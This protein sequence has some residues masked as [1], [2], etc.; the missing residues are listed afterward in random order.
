MTAVSAPPVVT[1]PVPRTLAIVLAAGE[2]TRM[3][4]Q[5]P[6]VLHEVAGL[7]MLGHVVR[8]A[9][10]AG[11]DGLTVVVGPGREGDVGA[12]ALR[13]APEAGIVVQHERRGTA[14]AVLTAAGS[15]AQGY[16]RVVVLFADTPLMSAPLLR[17]LADGLADGV[18]VAALGFRPADPTGYGRFI[19]AEGTLQAIREHKD[20]SEDERRIGLCNAGLMALA[21]REAL[22]ILGAIGN[23][24]AQG[25]FYLT[26][27]VQVARARGL[28]AVVVEAPEDA[29]M[30]VNDRAQLAAAEAIMQ[31]RLR[32]A[33]MRAGVTMLDPASTYLSHDTRF[34]RDVLLEPGVFCGRGVEIGE[35][36]VVHA[37]S[38]LEGCRIGPGASVGPFARLRPGAEIGPAAKIGNF[39]EIKNADVGAGAKISHLSY[40]GDADVGAE[41]NIGAGTITCNYD[42]FFKYRT[43]IGAQ[44]FVGSNS[45]LV[46]PVSIGEGAYVGSGSVVTEDVPADALAVARGRQAVKSGWAAAFRADASAR[47]QAAKAGK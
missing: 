15:I 47:K 41:A 8:A 13:H 39:V 26:D 10:E 43:R 33:A 16:D 28:G 2:G 11:F 35:G 38:H 32:L 30:G 24:N 22:A 44:A 6:K 25:E 29:V 18:G 21:G 34:G 7:S 17:A 5:R 36:A 27:A 23:A 42:G 9:V 3:R 14:H 37:H 40:I 1:T 45:A 4:S 12:E 19:T 31:Q 20:A 46:A